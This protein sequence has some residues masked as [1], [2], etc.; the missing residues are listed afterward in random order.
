M[1]NEIVVYDRAFAAERILGVKLQDWQSRPAPLLFS[2]PIPFRSG[3]A[4]FQAELLIWAMA[5]E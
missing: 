3:K 5:Q 4:T 1:G 2:K